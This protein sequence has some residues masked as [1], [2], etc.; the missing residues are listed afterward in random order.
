[1]LNFYS[2]LPAIYTKLHL[3]GVLFMSE[4][5]FTNSQN[6]QTATSQDDEPQVKVLPTPMS[7]T[8]LLKTLDTIH[9]QTNQNLSSAS[10]RSE[11]LLARVSVGQTNEMGLKLGEISRVVRSVNYDTQQKGVN[12]PIIGN[13]INRFVKKVDDYQAQFVS[14]NTQIARLVDEVDRIIVTVQQSLQMFEQDIQN[15]KNDLKSVMEFANHLE[16]D[17]LPQLGQ[18][19]E[20]KRLLLADN[21]SN[22]PL[23]LQEINDLLYKENNLKKNIDDL[24]IQETLLTQEIETLYLMHGSGRASESEYYTIKNVTLPIWKNQMAIHISLNEQQERAVIAQDFKETTQQLIQKNS[25]L[26]KSSIILSAKTAQ[27]TVVSVDTLIEVQNNLQDTI[28]SVLKIQQQ[29]EIDRKASQARLQKLNEQIRKGY[30]QQ[31]LEQYNPDNS[32]M[33]LNLSLSNYNAGEPTNK[34][35]NQ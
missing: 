11:Q 23:I 19:I 5:V 26:L 27:Q 14:A 20:S 22:N 13:V 15:R 34:G 2:F 7:E 30:T 10:Q 25:E 1:M 8:D 32:R 17:I 6:P 12:L 31:L 16:L 21:S 24:R 29:G 28:E 18:L 35:G 9:T 33:A 4:I 3:Y